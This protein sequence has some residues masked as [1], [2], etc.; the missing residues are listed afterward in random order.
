MEKACQRSPALCLY[1]MLTTD[2]STEKF[3]LY[4]NLMCIELRRGRKLEK[5][6]NDY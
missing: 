6:G 3:G 1:K 4:R 5:S 2:K